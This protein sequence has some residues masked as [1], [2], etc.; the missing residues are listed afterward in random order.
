MSH[1]EYLN[2]LYVDKCKFDEL[3]ETK[4]ELEKQLLSINENIS[5]IIGK[6]IAN[7]IYIREFNEST[8]CKKCNLIS[9]L[10]RNNL[11]YSCC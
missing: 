11:C 3:Q 9:A 6:K 2:W 5:N 8:K 7:R 4:I 1:N 10:V